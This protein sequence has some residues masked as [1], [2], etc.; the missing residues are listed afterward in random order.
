MPIRYSGARDEAIRYLRTQN[1][2][3]KL[4]NKIFQLE[5]WETETQVEKTEAK[6]KDAK[7]KAQPIL[8]ELAEVEKGKK[9]R[10]TKYQKEICE[11]KKI[12][13]DIEES[14]KNF[15]ALERKDIAKREEYKS[16]KLQGKKKTQQLE[17]E[18]AN[19]KDLETMPEAR[20]DLE[21]DQFVSPI[22]WLTV[23]VI[24]QG[25]RRDHIQFISKKS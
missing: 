13:Q 1:T 25:H 14:Q 16:I 24:H 11:Y 22:G 9:E 3:T 12:E 10:D 4:Y 21:R 15:E 18:E 20:L 2:I 17:K 8:D 19:R 7:E 5:K 6:L 23:V